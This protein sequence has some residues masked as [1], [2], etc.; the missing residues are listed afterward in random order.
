MCT[1]HNDTNFEEYVMKWRDK[2]VGDTNLVKD[3]HHC[4]IAKG[5]CEIDLLPTPLFSA[6][7]S[8]SHCAIFLRVRSDFKH[9][10]S[11]GL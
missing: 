2:K 4:R 10:H 9:M 3:T 7:F 1:D 11:P 6:A 8:K 5:L